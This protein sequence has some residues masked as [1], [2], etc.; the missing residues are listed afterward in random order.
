ME[1]EKRRAERLQVDLPAV[2]RSDE[3]SLRARVVNISLRGLFICS[4]RLDNRGRSADVELTIPGLREILDLAGE[5]VWARLVPRPSGMGINFDTP[6]PSQ[7]LVLANYLLAHYQ[8]LVQ[9]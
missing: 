4:G 8:R 3:I 7:R 2:Y 5:V 6:D 9:S 1:W